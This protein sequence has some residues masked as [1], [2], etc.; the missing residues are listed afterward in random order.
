M[1][2]TSPCLLRDD[3]K[4]RNNARQ[5]SGS[6][7][8]AECYRTVIPGDTRMSSPGPPSTIARFTPFLKTCNPV[9]GGFVC[10][11]LVYFG[12]PDL[13]SAEGGHPDLFRFPRFFF[14]RFVPICVS[15]FRECPDCSDVFRFT[16]FFPICSDLFSEQIRTN[17]RNPFL[18]TPFGNPRLI[19]LPRSPSPWECPPP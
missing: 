8:C 19:H 6:A 16:P 9:G 18:P 15:C 12:A 17:Q 10:L 2:A 14:F 13:G 7:Q 11:P 4:L 3:Q 1:S 5:Y